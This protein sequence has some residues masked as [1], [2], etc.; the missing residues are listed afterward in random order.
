MKGIDAGSL[1]PFELTESKISLFFSIVLMGVL[2]LVCL[3]LSE[4]F[5]VAFASL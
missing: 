3:H 5:E 2:L 1:A 4:V